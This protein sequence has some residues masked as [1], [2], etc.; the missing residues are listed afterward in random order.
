MY[1]SNT[2]DYH[3]MLF[4]T[5][6]RSNVAFWL[7]IEARIFLLRATW[8]RKY[9]V[10]GHGRELLRSVFCCQFKIATLFKP[11]MHIPLTVNTNIYVKTQFYHPH[12][13]NNFL[14]IPFCSWK[15]RY[16]VIIL[17]ETRVSLRSNSRHKSF[18]SLWV[19]FSSK[20]CFTRYQTN[21]NVYRKLIIIN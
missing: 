19:K 5:P 11:H 1:L 14:E 6:I 13:S 18:L 15:L 16:Y 4:C 9:I 7:I 21:K 20:C 10:R 17:Y 12:I 3:R 2:L 8:R